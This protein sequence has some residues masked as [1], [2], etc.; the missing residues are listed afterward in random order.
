HT[1][2]LPGIYQITVSIQDDGGSSLVV[3]ST[4]TIGAAPIV[5]TSTLVVV[6]ADA[7]PPQV[8]VFDVRTHAVLAAFYPYPIFFHGGVR[9]AIA[10]VNGDGVPD[11]IVGA[12]PGGGPQVRVYD[13]R[14]FQPMAGPLGNFYGLAPFFSGGVYVASGDIDGDGFADVIV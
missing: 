10:D 3:V 2:A 13:G 7:G 5:N 14:T 11:I 1:Y 4:V 6:G 12:G 9:T 8:S